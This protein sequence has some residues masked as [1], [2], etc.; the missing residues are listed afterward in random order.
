MQ[1]F[2]LTCAIGLGLWSALLLYSQLMTPL[3][4]AVE[5]PK[6]PPKM[7]TAAQQPIELDPVVQAA[8]PDQAWI[9]DASLQ[10]KRSQQSFMYAGS[11]QPDENSDGSALRMA[12][13]ALVWKDEKNPDRAPFTVVARS[14]RIRFEKAVFDTATARD[15]ERAS[16]FN[17][18]GEDAGRIVAAAL[19]G[20]VRITGPDNLVI[21]GRDFNFQ[22]ENAQLYSDYEVSFRYGPSDQGRPVALRGKSLDGLTVTF[23]PVPTSPLGADLPRVAEVPRTVQLRG[24]VTVDFVTE[25]QKRPAKTRV[26]SQGPFRYEFASRTATFSDRVLVTRPRPGNHKQ[27][28]DCNWLALVFGE[29]IPQ[30]TPDGIIHAST[31]DRPVETPTESLLSQ[32]ELL[33]I[34]AMAKSNPNSPQK[35]RLKLISSEN[36]LECEL[37]DLQYDA[38]RQTLTLTDP[39][40]VDVTR[41]AHGQTQKFDA[42]S[43][44]IRHTGEVLEQLSGIGKGS[45]SHRYVGTPKGPPEVRAQWNDRV[46]LIPHPDQNV[47]ELTIRGMATVQYLD[48]LVFNAAV[49]TAW[50]LPLEQM[51]GDLLETPQKLPRKS[52]PPRESPVQRIVASGNVAFAGPGVVGRQIQQ[53]DI[54][55]VSG[56]N[57]PVRQPQKAGREEDS[58]DQASASDPDNTPLVFEA[59]RLE[60]V[61]VFDAA[62]ND[63]GL[64]ELHGY[65]GVRL[66]REGVGEQ[67]DEDLPFDAQPIRVTSREFSATNNG[68]N[69][70]VLTLRGVVDEKGVVREPVIAKIGEFSLEG[71][72]VEIDREKNL[73]TIVGQ[74]VLR[75][76]V[77]EDLS[78]NPLNPPALADIACLEKIT[79]DGQRASF[80]GSV[81]ASV[82]TNVIWA[83]EMTAVLNQRIDFSADRPETRGLLIE[84]LHCQ[85]KVRVEMYEYAMLPGLSD[86]RNPRQVLVEI[87]KANLHDFDLNQ[88]SGE[89]TG[90]GPGKIQD[91]RRTGTPRMSVQMR[92]S[93]QAKPAD[94]NREY[95]WE[96]VGI[97]FEDKVTGN[98]QQRWGSLHDRVNLIYAPVKNANEIFVRNDLS[99]EKENAKNAVW[100]GSDLLTVWINGENGQAPMATVVAQQNAQQN[101]QMEGQLFYAQ[102]YKLTYEQA[103]EMFTLQGKG[104]DNATL[105]VKRDT[106]SQFSR[107]PARVIQFF[108][109]RQEVLIDGAKT[110]S[111]IFGGGTR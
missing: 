45:F 98:V 58:I 75:F 19:D 26:S 47:T 30:S 59:S 102:A 5:K 72:S 50:M 82:L 25:Q 108:P 103:K 24:R 3:T 91:W 20:E 35:E 22:E 62:L 31:D 60:G 56:Q 18:I 99:S 11:V 90:H 85:D 109:A 33:S 78:G 16:A 76:P 17:L 67:P 23:D 63:L 38:R 69:R 27:E 71:P 65:D 43:I 9:R 2:L 48:Q 37:N 95:P 41:T 80:L 52:R 57:I 64:Q 13:F 106:N 79:F 42:P 77:N 46:D 105:N 39:V 74:G 8:L 6:Q 32:I 104:Q 40:R 34:R 12:P 61:A 66:W 15:S 55:I 1:R 44:E 10:W 14:A 21:D 68:G 54:Q 70:Q 100:I 84:T 111:T 86:T 89:F 97:D 83:E 49:V 110:F 93:T 96:F 53:V 87:L 29:V 92:N 81:K 36:G 101:A 7:A 51:G 73:A 107:L 28:I 88:K 94:T 4:K